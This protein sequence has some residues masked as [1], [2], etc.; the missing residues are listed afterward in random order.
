MFYLLPNS[1]SRKDRDGP[2]GG[3][4]LIVQKAVR[5]NDVVFAPSFEV[6]DRNACPSGLNALSGYREAPGARAEIEHQPVVLPARHHD[7]AQS[8]VIDVSRCR[9]EKTASRASY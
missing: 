5:D 1:L 9:S 8:I 6:G 4:G 3:L 2:I 7:V